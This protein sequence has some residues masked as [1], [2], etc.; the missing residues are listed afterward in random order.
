M[1]IDSA[2]VD[3]TM[4]TADTTVREL[5]REEILAI[6]E[7]GAR[8]RLEMTAQGMLCAY[9]HGRLEDPGAVAD[10]LVLAD[11][12]RPDDPVLAD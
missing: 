12:L 6:L 9:R 4:Q 5:T 11:L 2:K 1:V 7:A 8:R 3:V 10:L